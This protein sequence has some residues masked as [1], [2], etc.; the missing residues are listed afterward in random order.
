ML[1]VV[2]IALSTWSFVTATG[3]QMNGARAFLILVGPLPNSLM[4]IRGKRGFQISFIRKVHPSSKRNQQ[5]EAHASLMC[6]A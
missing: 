4:Q 3:L 2:V 5:E 1:N 6:A